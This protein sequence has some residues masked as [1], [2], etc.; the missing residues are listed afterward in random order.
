[1]LK[2]REIAYYSL[3][4][5]LEPHVHTYA[6]GLGLLAGDTLRAAADLAMPMLGVTLLYRGG[7][8]KQAP[9]AEGATV[10][11]DPWEPE[12]TLREMT[13]RVGLPLDG[14]NV[15]V[16]AFRLDLHGH[17]G[18]VVPVYFLDTDLPENDDDA[19]AI[20][21]RLY[22]G[23]DAA[24]IRQEA[25]LGI[26]GP[27]ILRAIGHEPRINHLNEGHAAFLIVELLS[28]LVAAASDRGESAQSALDAA[29][30][31]DVR[32]RCVFTTHTPVP[33]GHDEF[34]LELVRQVVGDHPAFA[35]A[36]LMG[37][38]DVFHTTRLALAMSSY[39]NG[40]SKRHAE[41]TRR[42]FPDHPIHAVTNGVHA[43]SWVCPPL[44]RVFDAN[45]PEWRRDHSQLRLAASLPDEDLIPPH[46]E[47]RHALLDSLPQEARS[48]LDPDI[49][50]IVFARRMTGYKRPDLILAD[51]DRLAEIAREA[52]PFQLI[53]TGKAHP[54]DHQG[55]ECLANIQ[56]ISERLRGAVPIVFLP[57]Y[58]IG[59][60]R[61][62]VAGADVWLNNPRPPLEASGTSG[63]KAALNGVPSLSTLDGWWREGCVE[64]LTGW[65]IGAWDDDVG[66]QPEAVLDERH[67]HA[68]YDALQHRVL[69]S[70]YGQTSR[71]AD[72]MRACITI[73]GAHFTTQ[74]MLREYVVDAY[75]DAPA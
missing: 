10:Q 37:S 40:V 28:R 48:A 1:M 20:T 26:A 15:M 13:P 68:L 22:H 55:M 41:V 43:P 73:N 23:D 44:A 8:F 70:F 24:R 5:G 17:S 47:A 46:R 25:V 4:I 56:R 51:P 27:R 58:G 65:S 39:A 32:A 60:T 11:P 69:P 64:G 18:A 63:M 6:G 59:L 9:S 19:R 62:L 49:L 67:A 50:T 2:H 75:S 3:E 45:I 29:S 35:R 72:V 16:R 12:A 7:H 42:M 54:R 33:A 30:L 53:F 66:A 71:W 31:D 38:P 14:R 61:R 21:R 34:P 74:R 57:N 52:G 36:D